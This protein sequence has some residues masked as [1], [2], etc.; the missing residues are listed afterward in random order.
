MRDN[1]YGHQFLPA[2]RAPRLLEDTAGIRHFTRRQP[3]APRGGEPVRLTVTTSGGTPFAEIACWYG[4]SG[5]AESRVA[6]AAADT[7]WDHLSWDY[8][9][10]WTAQ[11]PAQA[12]GVV[13]RYVI[14]GRVAGSDRWVFADNQ[15][16]SRAA[17]TEFAV[18]I[19]EPAEPAWAREAVIYHI[20]LDRFAPGG[21][22]G[23][24]P[25]AQVTDFYG[26]TL[27]GVIEQLDYIRGL[28]FNTLWLSPVFPSPTPHGYDATDLFTVEPR[29]GTNADLIELFDC[30]HRK[31]LRVLLDFVPNHWSN[32]HPTFRAASENPDSPYRD[33][34]IWKEWPRSYE[35]FYNVQTMPK[36]NVGASSVRQHLLEAA[37]FW[38]AQGADGYRL[39]HANGPVQEF[40][41]D[42]RRACQ[43]AQPDCWL[44]G[45][46]VKPPPMQRTYYGNLHGNLDFALARAIRETFALGAWDFARLD[47]FLSAHFAYF[48]AGYSHPA[49]FDN[50]DMNRLL[51]L[52]GDDTRRLK[53]AAL[54]LFTLPGAPILYYG[55]ET[56]LSQ[57][58]SIADGLGFDEVRLPMR[59]GAE[60]DAGLVEYFRKLI[61]L[62]R[63]HP[64]ILSGERRTLLLDPARGLYAYAPAAGLVV[65]FNLSAKRHTL[66]IPID[67]KPGAADRLNGNRVFQGDGQIEIDL[68]PRGGAFILQGSS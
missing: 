7:T 26:G 21:G 67:L 4:T 56:G 57:Q 60:Q 2:Y 54:L 6:F 32:D 33:W 66:A 42:F 53:L 3:L 68:P 47:A 27:R 46:V 31:G 5:A 36:L 13:L 44:F 38:L 11:L 62:R 20:F 51:F 48:P 1:L 19:G 61:H 9:R 18:C 29:L 64:A 40:W 39:D 10:H 65:A 50:H 49:F 15:A 24:L 41:A 58:K 35:A 28:G 43:R 12:D 45:E 22:R 63:Q 8:V 14:G 59:W 52:A 17:A 37:Q 16:D 30:A 25:A 34:Y 55:T 23:W